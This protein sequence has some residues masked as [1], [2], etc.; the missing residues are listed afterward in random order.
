MNVIKWPHPPESSHKQHLWNEQE[1]VV[2]M[3]TQS[4]AGIG[5]EEGSAEVTIFADPAKS[6]NHVSNGP[7]DYPLPPEAHAASFKTNETRWVYVNAAGAFYADNVRPEWHPILHGW[8]RPW[9]NEADRAIVFIDPDLECGSRAIVMDSFNSMFE[10][11]QRIPDT[12]NEPPVWEI[13]PE[14]EMLWQTYEL[15]PGNYLFELCGGRGGCGGAGEV[16]ASA[17][18][19]RGGKGGAGAKGQALICK[20]RTLRPVFFQAFV[21][22]DGND[23]KNG[24]RITRWSHTNSR[25]SRPPAATGGGGGASGYDTLLRFLNNEAPIARALGGAGGGGGGA[26]IALQHQRQNLR[27]VLA[28]VSTGAVSGGGGGGAGYGGAGAGEA[29]SFDSDESDGRVSSGGEAGA[30]G[31]GGNGG[32]GIT[33]RNGQIS[34]IWSYPGESE[35]NIRDGGAAVAASMRNSSAALTPGGSGIS[36]SPSSGWFRCFRTGGP[37]LP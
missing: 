6:M 3:L 25:T 28:R 33:L 16:T 21:G 7:V 23:G 22:R 35:G 19:A 15:L 12:W 10:H 14:Q 1:Y 18:S 17:S 32:E 2:R 8:Y 36:S 4:S 24:N 30:I 13:S 11:D 29:G 5:I 37:A 34:A 9:P 26:V 27:K 20:I 31:S